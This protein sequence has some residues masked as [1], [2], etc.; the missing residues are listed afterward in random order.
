M[1]GVTGGGVSPVTLRV[2]TVSVTGDLYI[3]ST[4]IMYVVFL[5]HSH[6]IIVLSSVSLHKLTFP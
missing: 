3:V 1:L 5:F 4:L 2:Y 6:V